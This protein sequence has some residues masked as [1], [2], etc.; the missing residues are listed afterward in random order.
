[1]SRLAKI[2]VQD[3]DPELRGLTAADT[4]SAIEIG[5]LQIF[6]HRP[7]IAKAIVGL[8]V[9]LK[10][11]STLTERLMEIVRLRIAFHNQCR[12]CMAIR[13]RNA[14]SD[15][16]DETLV[17]A[18]E[19]PSSGDFTARE[20]AALKF[21]DLFAND[22]LAIDEAV[23]DGLRQHFTEG[24]LVELG[25]WDRILRGLRAS[26]GD[27]GHGG[28]IGAR[29]STARRRTVVALIREAVI[30]QVRRRRQM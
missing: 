11:S 21:A 25:S 28:G 9:A 3:W 14:V 30:G 4:A 13:Y 7:Q 8:G 2:A 16:V 15:G 18:I 22:H 6:A 17:C 29:V 5:P 24:Q 1:M 10:T 23:Y 27:L 20:R 19:Q 26:G 12:S